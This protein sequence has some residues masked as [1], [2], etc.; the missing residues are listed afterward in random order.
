MSRTDKLI[1][2]LRASES[3]FTWKELQTLLRRLGYRQL[4]GRG[5]RV[6]FDNGDPE[7]LISL[8]RPHPGTELK[9]YAREQ[10]IERLK[11]GG[12]L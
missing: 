1:S 10:V 12:L 4:Q 11:A 5:S 3:V 2:R 6:K 8:H 9:S 7:A